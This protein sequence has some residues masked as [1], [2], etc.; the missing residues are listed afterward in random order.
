[1]RRAVLLKV[2]PQLRKVVA[3]GI[4]AITPH[5]ITRLVGQNEVRAI[6]LTI[7]NDYP[8]RFVGAAAPVEHLRTL[9]R[10]QFGDS[11]VISGEGFLFGANKQGQAASAPLTAEQALEQ[12]VWLPPLS[13]IG[14]VLTT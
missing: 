14:G 8:L 9:P 2:R 1:M 11:M 7:W 10:W 4:V 12:I 6:E 5:A 13:E 3:V